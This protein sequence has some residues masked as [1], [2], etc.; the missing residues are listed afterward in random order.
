MKVC[1]KCKIE[2]PEYS[3]VKDVLRNKRVKN[4]TPCDIIIKEQILE[5]LTI[6]EHKE[7]HKLRYN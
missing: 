5:I 6:E 7:K 4:V 1:S 2:Y 3:K